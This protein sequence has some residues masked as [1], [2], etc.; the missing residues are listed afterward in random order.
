MV[1]WAFN[2]STQ[3]AEAGRSLSSRPTWSINLSELY[4]QRN[5][6]LKNRERDRQREGKRDR[7]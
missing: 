3:E 2:P 6:V 7:E 4:T 5:P 1:A